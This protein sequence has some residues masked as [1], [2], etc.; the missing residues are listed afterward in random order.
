MGSA[1]AGYGRVPGCWPSG[2]GYNLELLGNLALRSF[3]L[4][5][6]YS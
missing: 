3:K 4:S 2:I 1:E 6:L 5:P